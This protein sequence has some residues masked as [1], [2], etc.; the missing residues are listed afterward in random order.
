MI[1]LDAPVQI[2]IAAMVSL[3]AERF[4]D[5]ARVR[6]VPVGA[7]LDRGLVDNRES[8]TEEALGSVHVPGGTPKGVHQIAFSIRGAIKIAPLAFD[9]QVGLIHIPTPAYFELAFTPEFLGQQR[10]KLLL[11][12]PH[13]FV[14]E[15]PSPEE[16]QSLQDSAG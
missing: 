13:C 4:A 6:I 3:G 9:L 7:H 10:S 5:R 2:S 11:P 14:G 16:K 1:L 15:R 8:A 12:L